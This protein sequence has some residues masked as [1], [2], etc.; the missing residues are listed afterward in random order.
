VLTRGGELQGTIAEGGY[1]KFAKLLDVFRGPTRRLGPISPDKDPLGGSWI[2]VRRRP[3]AAAAVPGGNAEMDLN[4]D[5][6]T[7]RLLETPT[8]LLQLVQC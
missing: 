4:D 2:R 8:M 5:P 1:I 6:G 7:W 3:L